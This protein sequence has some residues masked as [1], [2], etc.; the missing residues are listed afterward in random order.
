[1]SL[2]LFLLLC[3]TIGSTFSFAQSPPV[4]K[5][6]TKVFD[7]HGKK[8]SD[9]YYWLSN[10]SDSNVINH[11]KSENA[12]VE[13]MLKHTE[14]MQKKLYDELV[15][16]IEQKSA[17]LPTKRNGWWYYTR[18][19]EG[20][21]YPYYARKKGTTTAKEEIMLDVPQM[22]KITRYI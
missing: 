9:D 1:M 4:I 6:E 7:E 15:G 2:K 13:S 5:K 14:P 20:K 12:Y 22:A 21:Q 11:L 18:F 17:S 8:R 3:F 10:P 19:D 16:R